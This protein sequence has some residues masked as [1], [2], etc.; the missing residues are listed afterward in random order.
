MT[1]LIDLYKQLT[2]ETPECFPIK[3]EG[4]NRKYIRLSSLNHSL[5]GVI[6]ENITENQA[7]FYISNHFLEQGL[8]VPKVLAISKDKLRYIQEDLGIDLR[9]YHKLMDMLYC[10]EPNILYIKDKGVIV[11]VGV[12]EIDYCKK[13]IIFYKD[14]LYNDEYVYGFYAYGKT[15]A[16]TKEEL[17]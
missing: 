2:G 11:Q 1:G 15:W 12:L 16:L 10:G 8:P 17:L 14:S 4:S 6:G 3:G 5:V 9:I 7:F 13:K